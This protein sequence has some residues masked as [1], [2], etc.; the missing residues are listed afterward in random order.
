MILPALFGLGSGL[1]VTVLSASVFSMGA[2]AVSRSM[3]AVYNLQKI[4]QAASGV[5]S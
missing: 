2:R 5:R 3:G 4:I 1:P